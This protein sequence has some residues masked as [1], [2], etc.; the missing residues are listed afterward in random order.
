M[1]AQWLE[2]AVAADVAS[3]DGRREDSSSMTPD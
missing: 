2:E 3:D 1:E